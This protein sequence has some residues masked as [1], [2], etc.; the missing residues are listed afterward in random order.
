MTGRT[1]ADEIAELR[2]QL[3]AAEK[4][5]EE[6]EARAQELGLRLHLRPWTQHLPPLGVPQPRSPDHDTTER[7]P[8]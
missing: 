5:I 7:R 8:R 1:P 6:L 2:A 3:A 4:R